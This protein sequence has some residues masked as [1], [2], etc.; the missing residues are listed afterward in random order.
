MNSR[1]YVNRGFVVTNREIEV[2]DLISKEFSN[3]EIASMLYLSE[4]TIQ[5]HRKNILRKLEVRNTA[6]MIRKGF[7]LRILSYNGMDLPYCSQCS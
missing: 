5:T 1:E 3:K 6:G 2:L 7:E 4:H